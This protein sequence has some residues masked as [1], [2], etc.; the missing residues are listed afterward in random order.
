MSEPTFDEIL[1]QAAE[2]S[3][4][5]MHEIVIACL[6]IAVLSGVTMYA[7]YGAITSDGWLTRSAFGFACGMCMGLVQACVTVAMAY[8][9]KR[10]KLDL[11]RGAILA[12]QQTLTNMRRRNSVTHEV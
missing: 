8:H 6:L 2:E 5:L 7:A 11:Q 12:M 1:N 9:K 3:E 4:F 10:R